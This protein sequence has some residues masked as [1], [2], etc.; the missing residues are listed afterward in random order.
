L[1]K[2][3]LGVESHELPREL[4]VELIVESSR[5]S[6]GVSTRVNLPRVELPGVELSGIELPRELL[7]EFPGVLHYYYITFHTSEQCQNSQ[8]A[9]LVD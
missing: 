3:L 9:C 6:P 8:K 1:P 2:V 5:I 4:S 7:V